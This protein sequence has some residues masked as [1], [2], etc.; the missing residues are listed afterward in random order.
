MKKLLLIIFFL[1]SVL[2]V[3]AQG[4][5]C[6][7]ADPFCTGTPYSFPASTGVPNLGSVGCLFTT[8]NP[9]WYFLQVGTSGQIIINM[10][11]TPAV[12]IDFI[13]WGPFTSLS[14]ACATNLFGNNVPTG[15]MC[16]YST[17]ANE[18]VNIGAAIAGQVYV[19]L[20]TNYSNQPCNI[21]FSQTGGTGA[22]TCTIVAPPVINNGPL[23][24]GQTL[25]LTV[26]NA[27]P[28]ATYQWTGP[29][30]WTSNLM[31]PTRPNVT[32]AMAGVYSMVMTVGGISSLPVTTT[33]VI[34]PNPIASAGSNSPVCVGNSLN[35]IS[36]GGTGYSWSG[37]G[38]YTNLT[39]NPSINPVTPA[40]AGTYTVTVTG[41]G[42]C[43]ATATTA[44]VVNPNPAVTATAVPPAICA[45]QCSV[46]TGAGA[47]TYV[48][49][50]GG[51]SGAFTNVCPVA[52][53]IYTVT[54][55]LTATGCT[56]SNTVTVTVNPLPVLTVTAT[57]P[58]IC[59]GGSST[60][61]VT[62]SVPGTSFTWSPGGLSG[63]SISV[64]PLVTTTYTVCGST[65]AGC[66][67]CATITLTVNP[68]PVISASA[69]PP[70]ICAGQSSTLTATSD[71]IGTTFVWNPGNLSGASISV[72]PLVTTI[73]TVCG[74]TP[75]GCSA[76][77][78]VTLTVNP[79][80]TMTAPANVVVCNTG[81]VAASNFISNPAGGTFAWTN[82]NTA[83]GIGAIGSG[84][85][86]AF[87]ATNT[88]TIPISGTITVT[89]TLSG[90][91]GTS[92][93]YTITVNPTP[94]VTVPANIT[95]C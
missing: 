54:G 21:G 52:T 67:A 45:G 49:T 73:Y 42:G 44:V 41:T 76:C 47:N 80:P 65:P 51:L 19:L 64:H 29:G 71:I 34:N 40:A 16:S 25:Q 74:T 31:N 7:N 85:I 94:T 68:L 69:L 86:P 39:Q 10:Q 48:Y 55:T 88:S 26:T 75:A 24:V 2:F 70:T 20:I 59:V 13:C 56:G 33:V 6:T 32:T 87:T 4:A 81:L 62:S 12:D 93:T 92:V 18:T 22:T 5:D 36:S 14:Q 28:G 78:T 84:N 8:P 60:L 9:A 77:T 15:P 72:H 91:P 1:F 89:P 38:G 63:P 79:N 53:T 23:C 90:C 83:I 95:V 57:P 27:T 37:P 11:S 50:P 82:S 3:K 66:S 46:I 61:S 35:L 43:T 17:A 30:P 58:A